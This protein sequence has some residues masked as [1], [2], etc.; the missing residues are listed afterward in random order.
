M[1]TPLLKDPDAYPSDEILRSVL[2]DSYPAYEDTMKQITGADH[3]LVPAVEL[4]QGRES[5]AVQSVL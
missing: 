1:E 5:L 3:G 2:K 4:L